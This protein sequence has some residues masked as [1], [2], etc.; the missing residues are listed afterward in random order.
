MRA[1][2]AATALLAIAGKASADAVDSYAREQ[3]LAM[4]I[5]G[6]SLAVVQH[7]RTVK[8][9]SYGL[10]NVELG[11]P[12]GPDT[13]FAIASM[14]KSFT[15]AAVL[16]LAQEGKLG[17]DDPIGRYLQPVPQAWNAVTVRHLLTHT[18][19]IKDHFFDFPFYPPVPALSSLNR[20]MEFTDQELLKAL[21]AAP[22]NFEPG[23]RYAYSGS[24]YVLLG[25]IIRSVTGRPYGELL[26][27]RIF[28][29]LGMSATRLIDLDEVIPNRAAGYR[30]SDGALRNGGFTGQTF[31]S[32]ADVSMLTTA[33]D[34]ARWFQAL[35]TDAGWKRILAQMETPATLTDGGAAM[36]PFGGSYGLGW[37]LSRYRTEP[38]GGH[39]GSFNTGFSSVM[40]RLPGKDL[41]VIVLTNQHDANPMQIAFGIVGLYDEGLRPPHAMKVEPERTPELTRRVERLVM[42]LMGGAADFQGDVV[43]FIRSRLAGYPSPPADQRPPISVSFIASED[44]PGSGFEL[45]GVRVARL[46]HYNVLIGGEPACL[47]FYFDAGGI[48]AAYSGY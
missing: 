42:G 15:A 22:L 29:P 23:E 1:L 17:L 26:H 6:L 36:A 10:A 3:M 43:P 7:G 35:S 9:G 2:L 30:W 47:T 19:G 25:M 24:G 48:I 33:G 4:H 38:I 31:S 11:V 34:L 28:K 12:V 40:V 41:S 13:R 16:L 5:P 21:T 37:Y 27:D 20:R 32:A 45:N 44:V 46:K 39:T 14:T 18:S 8:T